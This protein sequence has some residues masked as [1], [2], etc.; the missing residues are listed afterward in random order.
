MG[1][2]TAGVAMM[3]GAYQGLRP[4]QIP[5]ATGL[6]SV[7]QRVGGSFGTAVLAV[8]LQRVTEGTGT[9]AAL[10]GA[11]GETFWWTVGFALIALIPAWLL[12]RSGPA[13]ADRSAGRDQ[14]VGRGPGST[15]S[16]D[17]TGSSRRGRLRYRGRRG[18]PRR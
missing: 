10:Q 7:V 8:V 12:P 5:G 2:G 14:S 18:D 1:L 9:P 11:F 4:D 6:T 3:A 17:V 16:V 15:Q 13:P